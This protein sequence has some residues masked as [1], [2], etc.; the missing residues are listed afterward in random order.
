M[1]LSWKDA[2]STLLVAGAVTLTYA[3]VTGVNIP[4]LGSWRL[5][6]LALLVL[7]FATCI[8]AGWGAVP[9]QNVW[10]AIASVFGVL[11]LT[12]GVAGLV[13]ESR[14][15]FVALA[16]D[17][18]QLWLVSTLHHIIEAGGN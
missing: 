13:F 11:G 6:T 14:F 10:T 5:G 4:L 2:V 1:S 9:T 12:I 8:V 18:T 15:L 17:I 16:V 7:G 3:K